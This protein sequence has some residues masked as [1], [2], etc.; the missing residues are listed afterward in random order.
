[1]NNCQ[2]CGGDI[3]DFFEVK[4]MLLGYRDLFVYVRC[5]DCGCLQITEIPS[6]LSK[7]YPDN[8]YSLQ[9]VTKKKT[10]VVRDYIRKSSSLYNISGKGILG[11]FLALFKN[12][13][14]LHLVYRRIGLKSSDKILDVGGGSGLHALSLQRI[15]FKNALSVDP[16]I[17]NNIFFIVG[18]IFY[19]FI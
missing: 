4:E 19:I 6:N 14:P 10:R 5:S 7:Y 12:P 13:D 17:S 15:G 18:C 9:A 11:W 1:M 3:S 8:Y 16:F 2:I